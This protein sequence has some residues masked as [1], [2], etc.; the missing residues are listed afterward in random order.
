MTDFTHNNHLKYT[1][2]QG[3]YRST[4]I[5]K[6]NV[7]LG[8]IDSD[9]YACSSYANELHRTA[10]LVR[11]DLGNDLV[12]FLSG[13]TDSEI[14]LRNFIHTGFKP[15]CVVLRFENNYNAGEVAEAQAIA[16]ELDVKLNII[17]FDVHDFYN[18]GEAKE[19]GNQ[20]QCTQLTYN[21]VYKSILTLG[22]PAVMG[23]EALLTR[24]VSTTD[25]YW[26]YTFREN[27]D[28]SAMRFTNK[29]SIP[30]V[31]EWF[32]YTPELLL[33]YLEH[34]SIKE[35]TT[36]TNYKLTS[37]SSKNAILKQLYPNF[38]TK[39]KIHGFESLL[40][41]N[42]TAYKDLGHDQVKRLEFSLDGV[43]YTQ[44][45]AQLKGQQ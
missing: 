28:A 13:G 5:E 6:Y 3:Q 39:K 33:Y 8:T 32:S 25:S 21:M 18:S 37:A 42:L 14:V 31:N 9:R 29:F 43:E 44:A 38:R 23:G 24:Q 22:A 11:T 45:I 7:Q 41:F 20:I 10:E 1:I 35:L 17:D 19:F 34:P 30:L 15:Q 16:S 12:L 27:E 40:A 36:S 2:G 4:S 26:Y